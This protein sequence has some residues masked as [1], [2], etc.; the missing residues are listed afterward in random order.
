MQE[1]YYLNYVFLQ[2]KENVIM[3]KYAKLLGMLCL[4]SFLFYSCGEKAQSS[5]K[6]EE[7]V[8]KEV[9]TA[10]IEN[11]SNT[12]TNK[13]E[14]NGS[15]GVF[16]FETESHDFGPI[17]QGD[18]VEHTFKFKN[19]GEAPLVI[20]DIKASCGCTTP[21]WPKEPVAP[22]E[23]GEI[24]VKFNS[25][26]KIGLQ[27]KNVTITANVEGGKKIVT[28]KTNVEAAANTQNMMG[29]LKKAEK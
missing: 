16:E 26:G 2:R 24:L 5:E 27:Q 9:N 8:A 19:I 18:V 20:T 1:L 6:P 15:Y 21:S 23:E 13:E 29:P 10:T 4:S 3:K 11:V 14:A 7:A 17:K 12:E 22:N 25:K 28:I